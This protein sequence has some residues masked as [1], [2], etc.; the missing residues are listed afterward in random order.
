MNVGGRQLIVQ[1]N[2]TFSRNLPKGGRVYIAVALFPWAIIFLVNL[3]SI[4]LFH[5][6]QYKNQMPEAESRVFS[7]DVQ[8]IDINQ[9][10]VVDSNLAFLLADKKL[11]ERPALGSQVTLGYPTIQKVDD[12]LVWVVPL[13]HSGF[14]KWFSN[15]DGTPGYIVVSATNPRDVK[16]V[17]NFPIKYQPKRIF[18]IICSVIRAFG[19]MLTGLT[20]IL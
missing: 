12:K 11:G 14:F 9:L 10:P 3:Y 7:S 20:I 16:Y 17:A 18:S 5:V 13:L 2:G 1:N 8:A 6:D 15:A 4:V 19:A